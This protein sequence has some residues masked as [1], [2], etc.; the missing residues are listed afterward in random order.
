[1]M[2]DSPDEAKTQEPNWC[3]SNV[4]VGLD[5][6]IVQELLKQ[7]ASNPV[8]LFQSPAV[9]QS[10][11]MHRLETL[12]D[13]KVK[14]L[15]DNPPAA[16][17]DALQY[18]IDTMKTG[19]ALN[20]PDLL[21]NP[22]SSID[23]IRFRIGDL[24]VLTVGP[25]SES[26]IFSLLAAG[27]SPNRI[28]G[29]DL[30]SYSEFVDVGDMHDMPYPDNTFDVVILG[31]V[32]AYSKDNAQVAR[33]VRRVSSP[34]A[35]VA[36]GCQYLPYSREVLKEHDGDAFMDPTRFYNLNDI[37]SLWSGEISYVPF[38]HDIHPAMKD[39]V[40]DIMT[41]FQFDG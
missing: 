7:M 37:L 31:W 8:S 9:R 13:T 29:L 16:I 1:M 40:G 15:E 10:I 30:F 38:Q 33:E 25:R 3:S 23:L 4:D 18:N 39:N 17:R 26:E 24:K 5:V 41:I 34:G 21:I 35:F 22:L 11:A 20:R 19:V 27:F 32:L 12:D 6:N 36:V 14:A 2:S 28:R